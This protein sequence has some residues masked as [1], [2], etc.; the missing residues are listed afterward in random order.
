MCI[1]GMA[2]LSSTLMVVQSFGRGSYCKE[3]KCLE[4][5]ASQGSYVAHKVSNSCGGSCDVDGST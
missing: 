4:I 5:N 2:L 1:A 3:F